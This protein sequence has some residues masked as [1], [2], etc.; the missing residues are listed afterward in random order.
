MHIE[1]YRSRWLVKMFTAGQ[2]SKQARAQNEKQK[3]V[4]TSEMKQ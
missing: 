4:F 1:S 2:M 3:A